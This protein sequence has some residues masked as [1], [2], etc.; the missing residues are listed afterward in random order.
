MLWDWKDCWA[1]TLHDGNNSLDGKD[2]YNGLWIMCLTGNC[3]DAQEGHVQS[4]ADK[5]NVEQISQTLYS[6]MKLMTISVGW[7]YSWLKQSHRLRWGW[8]FVNCQKEEKYMTKIILT[9]WTINEV[10]TYQT[11]RLLTHSGSPFVSWAHFWYQNSAIHWADCHD[12]CRH[13]QNDLAEAWHV[14]CSPN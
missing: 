9:H 7:Q 8:F 5:K 4:G 6:V 2:S 12:N 13:N 11:L 10:M 14:K 3:G 1:D